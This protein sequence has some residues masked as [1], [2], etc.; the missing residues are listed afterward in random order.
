MTSTI[1]ALRTAVQTTSIKLGRFMAP[2]QIVEQRIAADELQGKAMRAQIAGLVADGVDPEVAKERVNPPKDFRFDSFAKV[3]MRAL[4]QPT[5]LTLGS[6]TK[7]DFGNNV[8]HRPTQELATALALLGLSHVSG[9][10]PGRMEAFGKAS[11][12][13]SQRSE[14]FEA[15]RRWRGSS[16]RVLLHIE[17]ERPHEFCLKENTV[18]PINNL[19]ERTAMMFCLGVPQGFIFE[20]GG[21]G[22]LEEFGR[23]GA[24]MQLYKLIMTAIPRK[25]PMILVDF[26]LSLVSDKAWEGMMTG[27]R[28]S[29]SDLLCSLLQQLRE[30]GTY[31][32]ALDLLM[33]TMEACGTAKRAHRTHIT[34]VSILDPRYVEKVVGILDASASEMF[35]MD[36]DAEIVTSYEGSIV[37]EWE[38]LNQRDL[39]ETARSLCS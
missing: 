28:E 35:P 6:G 4:G 37:K 30:R 9:G 10:G 27:A 18:W 17:Q 11:W 29:R 22:T 15:L 12:L 21:F 16:Y 32:D 25:V 26:P 34:R 8:F 20:P 38:A 1:E 39:F 31:W 5:Y 7:E 19:Y 2:L 14:D 3:Y 13:A 36:G 33:L 23:A 24:D